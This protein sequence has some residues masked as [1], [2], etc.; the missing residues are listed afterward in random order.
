MN[1]R[2]GCLDALTSAAN[3]KFVQWCRES[4][5]ELRVQKRH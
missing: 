5:R 3:P 2:A 4:E 1:Q